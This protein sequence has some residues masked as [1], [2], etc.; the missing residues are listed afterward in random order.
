MIKPPPEA[1]ALV[2]VREHIDDKFNLLTRDMHINNDS[3]RDE[4][5]LKLESIRHETSTVGVALGRLQ[6]HEGRMVKAEVKLKA[7]G[8]AML[9]VLF[10]GC[11]LTIIV[12]SH[13]GWLPVVPQLQKHRLAE[14]MPNPVTKMFDGQVL[15]R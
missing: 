4:V 12:G 15:K 1:E 7:I 9:F 11:V 2:R 6:S 14:P 13:E 8:W 5:N 10:T 3:L